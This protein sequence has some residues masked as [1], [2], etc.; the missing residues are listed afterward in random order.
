[1]S[2]EIKDDQIR[3]VVVAGPNGSGKSTVTEA[4]RNDSKFPPFYINADDISRDELSYIPDVHD[5]NILAAQLA[6]TRR[7]QALSNHETFAFET[8]MSTPGKIA[9]FEEALYQGYTVDLIFITTKNYNIN[10]VR[11]ENRVAQGGHDVDP[12]K[13][14]ERY[15]RTMKLL[16]SAAEK[17]S[18]LEVY[19]NSGLSPLLIATKNATGFVIYNSAGKWID[20]FL[21]IP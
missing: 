13:I 16:P 7:K 5:R 14:K 3:M 1:M 12:L 2:D 4:L 20:N 17:C 6:E 15:D 21:K 11:V 18:S 9:L 10:V 8:V 19:D